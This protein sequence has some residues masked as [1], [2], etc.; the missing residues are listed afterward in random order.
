MGADTSEAA[1]AAVGGTLD[2]AT[3]IGGDAT[4]TIRDALLSAAALP[5]DVIEAALKGSDD[6][7]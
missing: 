2:A 4:Q 7:Q 3:S 6:K 5:R 1:K